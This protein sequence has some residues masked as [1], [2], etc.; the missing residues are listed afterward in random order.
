MKDKTVT[1]HGSPGEAR[2]AASIQSE[3]SLTSLDKDF[4]VS[5]V[6][7]VRDEVDS[8]PELIASLQSQTFPPAEVVMVDGGSTDETV[9]LARQLTADDDRFRVLEAGK[10]T[11]GRGRN[12]GIAAARHDWI[13]MSDAGNRLEPR[14]LECLLTVVQHDP[15]IAFV[16]G[17]FEPIVDSFFTRCASL[18]Y[19]PPKQARPGGLIRGPSIAS[20]LVRRDVWRQVGGFPDLRA[21]EDLIFMETIEQQGYKVGWAPQATSWWHIQPTL[22]RTYKRF[23][24]YS[25]Y[26]VWAGRQ[27]FWHYGIARQYLVLMIFLGLAFVHSPWWLAVVAVGLT[28]RVAKRIWSRREGHGAGWLFNPIQFLGVA[29]VI[30]TVDLATFVGWAQALWQRPAVT[31]HPE[32]VG[33]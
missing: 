2:T 32:S 10:A 28:A 6:I 21:A 5:V 7:P 30:L 18:A 25:R 12:I 9:A 16:Y 29:V 13:A 11:P 3:L 14:W 1:E 24:V 22:R 17:N 8:L 27:R 4:K 20:S 19:I 31:V 15:A 33:D 23:E 26:N